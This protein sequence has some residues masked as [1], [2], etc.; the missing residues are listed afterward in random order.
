MKC[1]SLCIALLLLPAVAFSAV[2]KLPD[3][4]PDPLD[5]L[6]EPPYWNLS[7]RLSQRDA[8]AENQAPFF[9]YDNHGTRHY[10]YTGGTQELNHFLSRCDEAIEPN[11]KEG[12]YSSV[13]S[14][15]V[16][17]H[18]GV[19]FARLPFET[20]DSPERRAQWHL[21]VAPQITAGREPNKETR[22]LVI[23]VHVW[24]DD[25]IRLDALQVPERFEVKTGGE[26]E[27]FIA[28]RRKSA[29]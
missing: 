8:P 24:I 5:L 6:P 10:Y 7:W 4:V 20:A 3:P 15:T 11:R 16:V 19:G 1:I 9:G 25:Q 12:W 13:S 23:I 18:S 17:L 22:T 28:N 26:L 29:E 21:V 27:S 2:I 14:T